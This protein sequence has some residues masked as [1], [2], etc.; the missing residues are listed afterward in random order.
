M[1]AMQVQNSLAELGL[2]AVLNDMF[3]KLDWSVSQ[4][5]ANSRGIHGL[6]CHCNPKSALKIQYL[7]LI[8]NFCDRDSCNRANKQLLLS[9][10]IS[11]T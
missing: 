10:N 7:R 6:G 5:R 3:D 9:P 1:G 4:S 11:K 2:V 8:H